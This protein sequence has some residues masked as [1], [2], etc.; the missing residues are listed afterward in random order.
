MV[1]VSP[2]AVLLGVALL[3]TPVGAQAPATVTVGGLTCHTSANGVYLLQP[4]PLNGRPHYYAT[5]GGGWHLY[6]SSQV[7]HCKCDPP[8]SQLT[9]RLDP[10]ARS[11]LRQQC[12]YR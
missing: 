10:G 9:S 6:W 7:V 12:Y 4:A 3:S 11:I 1:P 2:L 5:V 8:S